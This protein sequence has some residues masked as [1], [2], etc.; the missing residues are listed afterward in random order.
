MQGNRS[1]R[2]SHSLLFAN[3]LIFCFSSIFTYCLQF[4]LIHIGLLLHSP[5]ADHSR[6]DAWR[7]EHPDSGFYYSIISV[8]RIKY[9]TVVCTI[10]GK[11]SDP[12]ISATTAKL[13]KS[14]DQRSRNLLSSHCRDEECR[15]RRPSDTK[16]ACILQFFRP[17]ELHWL[18]QTV[19]SLQRYNGNKFIVIT[20][21][22]K[23]P[24]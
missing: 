16:C 18:T 17:S 11:H 10:I 14:V 7:S 15:C 24:D 9:Q 2:A 22:G 12:I 19:E 4:S 20:E 21:F 5:L 3:T 23:L 8:I 13:L 6:Q 1:N